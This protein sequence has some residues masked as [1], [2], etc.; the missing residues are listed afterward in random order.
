MQPHNSFQGSFTMCEF[1]TFSRN[2][3]ATYLKVIGRD[4]VNDLVG[5]NVEVRITE[6]LTVRMAHTDYGVTV[7]A[8]WEDARVTDV[9]GRVD[10]RKSL[11][12]DIVATHYFVERV[13]QQNPIL[14]VNVRVFAE[15]DQLF[16]KD[17]A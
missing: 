15:V 8:V 12:E 13:L 6:N 11:A 1:K 7:F 17:A 10:F 16:V 2:T 3:F 4:F 9:A 14:P 5:K